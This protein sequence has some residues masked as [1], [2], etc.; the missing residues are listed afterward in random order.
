MREKLSRRKYRVTKRKNSSMLEK[1]EPLSS[2]PFS[3]AF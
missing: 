1:I 2:Y 3:A